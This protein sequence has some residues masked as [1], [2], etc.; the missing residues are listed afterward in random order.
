MPSSHSAFGWWIA[1]YV[2]L[3][4]FGVSRP[5]MTMAFRSVVSAGAVVFACGVSFSRVYLLYHFKGQVVAGASF[6]ALQSALWFALTVSL[7]QPKVFP[8][9]EELA[10]SRWLLLKDSSSTDGVLEVEYM[11]QRERRGLSLRVVAATKKVR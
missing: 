5:S 10:V 1:T 8:W 9:V 3:Q 11:A 2:V 4:C 6:G 7:L